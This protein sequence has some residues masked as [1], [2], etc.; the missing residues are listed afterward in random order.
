MSSH[1]L[2]LLPAQGR[3]AENRDR[4]GPHAGWNRLAAEIISNRRLCAACDER[5]SMLRI[6]WWDIKIVDTIADNASSGL[7]V[8]GTSHKIAGGL[9]MRHSDGS[10]RRSGVLMAQARPCLDNP[11]R[12]RSAGWRETM[13]DNRYTSGKATSFSL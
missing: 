3:G 5:S 10:E 6:T 13:A 11:L 2:V 7:F 1:A 9:R 8:L 4:H 12:L